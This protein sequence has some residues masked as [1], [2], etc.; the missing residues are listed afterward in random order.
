MLPGKKEMTIQDIIIIAREKSKWFRRPHW[1]KDYLLEAAH[2]GLI[3][4]NQTFQYQCPE[5]R[6]TQEDLLAIDWELVDVL[7]KDFDY[8]E[9]GIIQNNEPLYKRVKK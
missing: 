8:V 6:F 5:H 4:T 2:N 9:T 7:G 3:H 1:R